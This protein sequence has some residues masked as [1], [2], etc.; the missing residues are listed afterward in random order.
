MVVNA[1]RDDEWVADPRLALLLAMLSRTRLV[2]Y[3]CTLLGIGGEQVTLT[4]RCEAI[5]SGAEPSGLR[6]TPT[7]KTALDAVGFAVM[8]RDQRALG[9]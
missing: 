9:L 7:V 3:V 4:N 5:A 1:L 8:D 2:G 6:I